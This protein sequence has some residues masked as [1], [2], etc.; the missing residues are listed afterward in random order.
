MTLLAS[1]ETQLATLSRM[2]DQQARQGLDAWNILT[3]EAMKSMMRSA[4]YRRCG[5]REKALTERKKEI[6]R[7]RYVPRTP[8]NRLFGSAMMSLQ[9]Q[10]RPCMDQLP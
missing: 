6:D 2:K 4:A 5:W 8:A 3:A 10:Y 1:R 9:L 7:P